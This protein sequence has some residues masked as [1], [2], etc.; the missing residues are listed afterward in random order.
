M[1]APPSYADTVPNDIPRRVFIFMRTGHGEA[2]DYVGDVY[3]YCDA[4]KS[5]SALAKVVLARATDVYPQLSPVE[6]RRCCIF[7]VCTLRIVRR[8]LR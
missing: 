6:S 7:E 1:A 2:Y 5:P 4:H 3:V 8:S